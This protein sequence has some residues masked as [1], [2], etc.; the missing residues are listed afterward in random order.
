MN[1]KSPLR[2]RVYGS[3]EGIKAERDGAQEL[4]VRVSETNETRLA[5]N[6]TALN[7]IAI[8]GY[9]VLLNTSAVDLGL[10]T[11]G[12]DFVIAVLREEFRSD[13]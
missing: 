2:T 6:L 10:G 9:R 1:L 12:L 11:G 7:G 13:Q 4:V 3:V 8:S 5:L